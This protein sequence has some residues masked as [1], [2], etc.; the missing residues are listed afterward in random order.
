MTFDPTLHLGDL[1]T[2]IALGGAAYQRVAA[3]LR[4]IERFMDESRED[5]LSLHRRL[6]LMERQFAE[7]R[8]HGD[9]F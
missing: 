7:L 9:A 4:A 1:L 3:T 6:D 5:R 2:I 8:R